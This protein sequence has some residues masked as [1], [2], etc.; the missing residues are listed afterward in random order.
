[1]SFRAPASQ[2]AVLCY[3]SDADETNG[4]LRVLP[5]SHLRYT[6]LHEMLPEPHGDEANR[7]ALDHPAMS[8]APGQVTMRVRAGDAVALDY[9][10]LHGTHANA[11]KLRRDA[12]LLSFTPD[13]SALPADIRGHLISHPA[14]LAE[15][16]T[17]AA[18]VILGDLLPEFRGPAKDLPV[19]RLRPRGR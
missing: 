11:S 17:R 10:L 3:L 16:E 1:V 19:L 8:D 4:A 6:P 12:I 2:I 15:D 18:R 7:L 13:W 14:L 9:R 5:G